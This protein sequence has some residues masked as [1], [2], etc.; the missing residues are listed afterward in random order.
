MGFET[1][2][3]LQ[4]EGDKD[5][6][7]S[8]DRCDGMRGDAVG[9]ELAVFNLFGCIAM[10]G[11]GVLEDNVAVDNGHQRVYHQVAALREEVKNHNVPGSRRVRGPEAPSF[12]NHRHVW[13]PYNLEDRDAHSH[14]AGMHHVVH[15]P[16][17][18]THN[19][20]FHG[21]VGAGRKSTLGVVST[22]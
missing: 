2:S 17:R 20:P 13:Y 9:L 11:G 15:S 7:S 1:A 21:F 22:G 18:A 16:I 6:G 8:M 14:Q 5:M 3:I 10:D 12:C 19:M 4:C